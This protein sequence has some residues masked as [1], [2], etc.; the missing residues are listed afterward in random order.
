MNRPELIL[1]H[2]L[3][4]ATLR[5]IEESEQN[6]IFCRHEMTHFQMVFQLMRAKS[7]GE[8]WAVSADILFACAYLHDIGRAEQYEN[9]TPHDIASLAYAKVILTDCGYT[10][11]EVTAVLSAIAVHRREEDGAPH[12][13]Q[14]YWAD[15]KSRPCR[16]CD[17]SGACN[18]SEDKKNKCMEPVLCESETEILKPQ[19]IPM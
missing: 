15:K 13:R 5:K 16:E 14:L 18:W 4:V 19:D 17:A 8:K 2:P 3:F 9:A 7:Q 10:D 11:D 1:T 6:R 12:A